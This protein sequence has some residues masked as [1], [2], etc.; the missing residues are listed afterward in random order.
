[1]AVLGFPGLDSSGTKRE[2]INAETH[3]AFS[4]FVGISH[5]NLSGSRLAF[6]TAAK[7]AA[8]VPAAAA[9]TAQTA[10]APGHYRVVEQIGQTLGGNRMLSRRGRNFFF[11]TKGGNFCM[12]V[13]QLKSSGGVSNG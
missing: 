5:C 12:A 2:G 10:T 4:D 8:T 9:T 3:L 7:R 1:M 6:G 13:G 11:K